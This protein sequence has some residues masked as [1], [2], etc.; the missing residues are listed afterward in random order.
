MDR[1]LF[2][3]ACANLA[4]ESYDADRDAVLAR[5]RAAGVAGFLVPGAS[6]EESRRAAALHARHPE[7]IWATAGV[8]PHHASSWSEEVA[9]GIEDLLDRPG[10]VGLGECGL[11]YFRLLST[12]AEQRRAFAAQIALARRHDR[13]LLLHVR[14]AH[15]DFL[16]LW[17]EGGVPAARAL[18]HCFTGTADELEETLAEGFVVG[19]T[20]WITDERRGA[21]L[22]PLIA[23]IARDRLVVE[24][25]CPYLLPR[26]LRPR[27]RSRRNEPAHLP[28]VASAIARAWGTDPAEVARSTTANLR[29]LFAL[30]EPVP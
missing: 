20:G 15:A 27:P 5:A 3:D 18:V 14:E 22:P 4:H 10:V 30:P 29:R 1:P 8:H 11:D 25:D 26:D 17:R 28:H 24:T 2:L 23:R 16:A 21:H 19:L 12:R 13:P 6:L 7:R 9:R